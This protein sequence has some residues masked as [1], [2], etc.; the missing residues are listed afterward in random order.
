MM[1]S[2][3]AGKG[4]DILQSPSSKLIHVSCMYLDALVSLGNNTRTTA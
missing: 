1:N 2:I 3:I 4:I